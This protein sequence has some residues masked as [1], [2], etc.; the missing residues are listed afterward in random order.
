MTKSE[1][2]E[3]LE[4]IVEHRDGLEVTLVFIGKS[5]SGKST[6]AKAVSDNFRYDLI[7]SHTT[8]PKRDGEV[9]GVDYHFVSE[10]EFQRIRELGGMLEVTKYRDW[11]YGISNKEFYDKPLSIVVTDPVG[12]RNLRRAGVSLIS[13]LVERGDKERFVSLVN[14][15]DNIME[16]ALRE[17]RDKACFQDAEEEV[18]FV[19]HN[20]GHVSEL[21]TQVLEGVRI[22]VERNE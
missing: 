21:C 17:E 14:R 12:L 18:D 5:G 13:F 11:Y 3:A 6:I 20:R 19:I 4:R 7:V 22:S 15:G 8:R 2:T 16:I 10:E 1:F 9:D